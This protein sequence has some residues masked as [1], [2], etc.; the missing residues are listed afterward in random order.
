MQPFLAFLFIAG[1]ARFL[2]EAANTK[3]PLEAFD[4]QWGKTEYNHCN[5]AANAAFMQQVEKDV[6]YILNLVRQYP[7]EFNNTVLAQWPAYTNRP[8]L[9]TNQY[10]TSLV[11]TL[12][13]MKPAGILKADSL[14]WVSAQCH[15]YSSGKTGYVGHERVSPPCEKLKHLNGECCQYGYSKAIEIVVDLLIDE[16]I[17]SLGHRF[18]CLSPYY[19]VV[20][21]SIQPH[22]SYG[23]NTVLDFSH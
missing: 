21:V 3:N 12:S 10:Y 8:G 20:G 22:K 5:T 19:G 13:A 1:I 15:A 11:K 9:A 17:P 4:P 7:R 6:V 16:G 2:P 14:C 23:V 18:I